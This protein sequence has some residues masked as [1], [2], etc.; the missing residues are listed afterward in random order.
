MRFDFASASVGAKAI[1]RPSD[2]SVKRRVMWDPPHREVSSVRHV[3][4]RK[5]SSAIVTPPSLQAGIHD[6]THQGPAGL[7]PAGAPEAGVG[8]LAAEQ[9]G[10]ESTAGCLAP[11]TYEDDRDDNAGPMRAAD[12]AGGSR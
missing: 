10:A 11:T 12:F 4:V 7:P 1:A 2:T 6:A 3:V 8:V 5:N 9:A